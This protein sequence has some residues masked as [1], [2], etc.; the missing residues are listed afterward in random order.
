MLDSAMNVLADQGAGIALAALAI[1]A[2]LAWRWRRQ[3]RHLIQA[4]DAMSQG[5]C[6]WS[7]KGQLLLCNRRYIEMYAM[8]PDVVKPGASLR[9]IVRNRLERGNFHGDIDQFVDGILARSKLR[10]AGVHTLEV[11]GRT[12][13]VSERP[14]A[15]GWIAT[16]DDVTELHRVEL[17]RARS[18]EEARRRDAVEGA[19]AEFRPQIGRASCRERVWIPV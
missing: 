3:N 11:N 12:I 17:E 15:D 1:V 16:H 13:S 19:I 7:S 18:G 4:L 8:S 14:T 2:A 10:R 9:D 6:L 5:L